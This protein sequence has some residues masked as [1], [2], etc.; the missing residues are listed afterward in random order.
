M[1]SLD[2]YV[3]ETTRHADLILTM[4][5][6]HRNAIVAQWPEL[7]ARTVLYSADSHDVSDP[8]G[9]AT[10]VYASCAEQLSA[11]VGHWADLIIEQALAYSASYHFNPGKRRISPA[12]K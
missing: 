9:Q 3:N 2:Y 1:V 11:S 12:T 8:I 5:E 7:A 4:T 6:G 10:P